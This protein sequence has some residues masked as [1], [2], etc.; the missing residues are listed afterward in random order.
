MRWLLLLLALPAFAGGF[1]SHV[2]GNDDGIYRMNDEALAIAATPF[3][4]TVTCTGAI[5]ITGTATGAGAVSWAASPDGASGACTGTGSW[6]CAV[7]VSPNAAGEGVETITV[8]QAGGASRTVDVGFYVAGAHSCFLAQSYDGAY[9]AGK[10]DLA[11]VATWVNL[12]SSALN[13]TQATGSAQPTYRTG[14]VGGS[15]VIRMDSGDSVAAATAADWNFMH[16]GGAFTVH[17]VWSAGVADPNVRAPIVGTRTPTLFGAGSLIYYDDRAASSAANRYCAVMGDGVSALNFSFVGADET[18]TQR[19]WNSTEL[20]F[21]DDGGAGVDATHYVN[22]T[23]IGTS[24]RSGAFGVGNAQLPLTIGNSSSVAPDFFSVLVYQSALTTTQIGINK[25]VTQWALG[26]TLPIVALAPG[27]ALWLFAGDSITA[28]S[29]GVT[30]WPTKLAVIASPTINFENRAASGATAAQILTQFTNATP[31]YPEKV[32]VLGG[33]NS[34]VA[35]ATGAA[36]YASLSPIYSEAASNGAQ[37]VALITPPFG[38]S[39]SWTAGR[40]TELEALASLI[41][42][43][44]NVDVVINLYALLGDPADL[45]NF[46]PIYR[47]DS[48]HPNE[49]GT[50]LI[51]ATVAT[52]LGI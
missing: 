41:S 46:N 26:A 45:K 50:A 21:S 47:V 27:D 20:V 19:F 11:A 17:A 16:T 18:I 12:G 36:A 51:A 39:G 42:A 15:P 44:P 28:G 24:L 6:S 1:G 13:V 5:T 49:D 10:A 22:G 34:I 23:S 40:Q 29:G 37:V 38:T 3:A 43:D 4:R 2:V 35:D 14:I 9:N 48:I 52:A 7:A 30:N 25:E 31:P 8:S 32:F 33:I